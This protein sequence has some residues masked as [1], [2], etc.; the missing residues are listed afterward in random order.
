MLPK[1]GP[2]GKNRRRRMRAMEGQLFRLETMDEATFAAW[3][4]RTATMYAE[5]KV[6]AGNWR[7]EEADELS[8]Q[9]FQRLLPQGRD[10]PNQEIRV[11]VADGAQVGQTWFTI[12]QR[13][14][15]RVVFIYDIEV[16]EE[17]RRHGY[18]RLAL[19]EVEGYAREHDCMG[20]MLHVFGNNTPARSL[21]R[22][23]G[24][25][26]TNVIMLKRVDA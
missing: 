16:W 22:T 4:A 20:V 2:G 11:M 6:K 5:E 19:A 13:D 25:E 9:E 3:R 26:E 15:G 24:F 7:P 12:E 17:H 18:G 23:A 10:T 1:T 8:E 21:Y 14:P